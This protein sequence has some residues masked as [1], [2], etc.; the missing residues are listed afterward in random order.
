M[1]ATSP[2]V[3]VRVFSDLSG[4]V[5]SIDARDSTVIGM[6]APLPSPV[7]GANARF[8]IN[9]PVAVSTDDRE[10]I[11]L[12]G[13]GS[14]KDA[15]TQIAAEG[16]VTNVVFVRA[17]TASDEQSQA[18]LV[19]GSASSKTGIWALVDAL[20]ETKLEPGIIIAPG[21]TTQAPQNGASPVAT[22]IDGVCE[23]IIDCIGVVDTP[24]TSR[25]DAIE[26]AEHF[27]TSLNI[28]AMYPRV[29]FLSSSGSVVD[30]RASASV[31]GAIVR[32]DK[33]NGHPYD[34]F[35]N[36]PLKGV[37]GTSV[38]VSYYDGRTDHDANILNFG[39]VG[40]IIEGKLLWS[41]FTTAT[42]PTVKAWRSIKRIR[43]RRSIE[44]AIPRALRQ[45]LGR[46]LGPHAVT[47]ISTA[48]A[49]AIRERIAF[50]A[51]IDGE[52]VF[53][54]S[55]N[56]QTTLRDGILRLTFRAEETPDL[57]DLQIDS[58]PMPEAFVT[59]TSSIEAALSTLG[60]PNIR[61]AA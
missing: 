16:I 49:E 4:T 30:G 5:A 8:P 33:A 37:L 6:S 40:T 9:E 22:A 13:P 3:G 59:L 25:E 45:Y 10:A 54:K 12:M 14:A 29:R 56:N 26:Y 58:V 60:D 11:A 18:G 20:S 31:A 21:Y 35:W 50:G 1:S 34:A 52:V 38:G 7:N 42:D 61:V 47:L 48:L 57:T 39:G 46:D 2:N 43:T 32:N 55:L 17:E 27:A 36:K 19:A 15:M 51:L 23:R 28:V 44:K 41:P 53:P 24:V